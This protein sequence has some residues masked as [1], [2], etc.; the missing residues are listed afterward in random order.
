MDSIPGTV[1]DG[2]IYQPS[3]CGVEAGSSEVQSHPQLQI[4]FEDNLGP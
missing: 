1:C 2:N 4:E 3:T